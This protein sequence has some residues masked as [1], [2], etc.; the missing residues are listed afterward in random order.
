MHT[1]PF[2]AS[3]LLEACGVGIIAVGNDSCSR[4]LGVPEF[5]RKGAI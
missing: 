3:I 4:K 2:L 5:W 1:E